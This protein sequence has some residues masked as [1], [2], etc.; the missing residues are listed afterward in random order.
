MKSDIEILVKL[1]HAEGWFSDEFTENN[2][3]G[4]VYNLEALTHE[5]AHVVS[6]GEK[7][8]VI[9]TKEV[10]LLIKERF[11]TNTDRDH[12]EIITSA[13]TREVLSR[14]NVECDDML[15]DNMMMNLSKETYKLGRFEV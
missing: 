8:E 1:I 15:F 12:N 9:S 14:F 4:V 7:I 6:C 11:K 13:I 3:Y 2:T 5:I 10:D